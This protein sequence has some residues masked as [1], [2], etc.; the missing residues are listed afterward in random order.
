MC[1][2]KKVQGGGAVGDGHRVGDATPTR[3]R[4]LEVF[5]DRALCELAAVQHSE[6][7]LALLI[8]DLRS[9]YRNRLQGVQLSPHVMDWS[10]GSRAVPRAGD[11]GLLHI[12]ESKMAT[13]MPVTEAG[14]KVTFLTQY[15]P[16]EVGAPQGRMYELAKRLVAAGH[17]V[18]VITAFPN[19]P[20]GIIQEGY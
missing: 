14:L 5:D 1:K 17:D 10:P 13:D 3:E 7:R 4:S 15:F 11:S 9:S 2:E 18:T 20:D 16:P 12:R 8:A 19:Y 6:Y